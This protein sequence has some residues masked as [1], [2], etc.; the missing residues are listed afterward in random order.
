MIAENVISFKDH[1]KN[2]NFFKELPERRKFHK[3]KAGTTQFCFKDYAKCD[4]HSMI[5]KNKIDNSSNNRRN[6][7]FV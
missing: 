4:F 5:T 2:V 7:K 3:R 1:E 6:V